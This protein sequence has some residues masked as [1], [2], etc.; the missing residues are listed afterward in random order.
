MSPSSSRGCSPGLPST[1][2]SV[3]LHVD[4]V[5]ARQV[6]VFVGFAAFQRRVPA[7]RVAV[8][9]GVERDRIAQRRDRAVVEVGRPHRDVAQGRRLEG[10]AQRGERDL[11]RQ[12]RFEPWALAQAEIEGLRIG[13]GG[14]R[15]VA[16]DAERDIGEVGEQPVARFLRLRLAGVAGDAIAAFGIDEQ[17]QAA[18]LQRRELLRA[19]Q[20]S[21]RTWRRRA[22]KR[23]EAS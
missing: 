11:L 7:L 20:G 22:R 2:T 4:L 17:R 10:A 12:D 23:P 16:R 8:A 19:A 5:G 1:A 6:I 21:R 3:A 15:R 18:R 14:D 13:V 9:G